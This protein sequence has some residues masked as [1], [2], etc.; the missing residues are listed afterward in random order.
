MEPWRLVVLLIARPE[1]LVFIGIPDSAGPIRMTALVFP[2][3][4]ALGEPSLL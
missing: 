1:G 4:E 2:F 3:A